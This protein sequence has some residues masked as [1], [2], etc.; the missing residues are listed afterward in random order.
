MPRNKSIST[1]FGFMLG[2]P[3]ALPLLPEGYSFVALQPVFAY[4]LPSFN[5]LNIKSSGLLGSPAHAGGLCLS[6]ATILIV[7]DKS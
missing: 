1:F 3:S 4:N 6:S 2:T 7:R 5:A